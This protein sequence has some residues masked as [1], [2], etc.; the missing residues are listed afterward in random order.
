MTRLFY[1]FQFHHTNNVSMTGW[2]YL[3]IKYDFILRDAILKKKKRIL[4]RIELI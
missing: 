1:F 3:I 4:K 2:F